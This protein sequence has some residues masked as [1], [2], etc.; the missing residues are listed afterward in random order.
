MVG[1]PGKG[2]SIALGCTELVPNWADRTKSTGEHRKHHLKSRNKAVL[3]GNLVSHPGVHLGFAWPWCWGDDV[4]CS[5]D[6]FELYNLTPGVGAAAPQPHKRHSMKSFILQETSK[7]FKSP[8]LLKQQC[9]SSLT[10]HT[11]I[12]SF[13]QGG[14]ASRAGFLPWVLLRLWAGYFAIGLSCAVY[15]LYSSRCPGD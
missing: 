7:P 11:R 9:N 1:G 10:I 3:S 5:Q 4:S 13:P 8:V 2:E 14:I 12:A 6:H 15:G